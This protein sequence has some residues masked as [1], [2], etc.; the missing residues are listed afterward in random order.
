MVIFLDDFS[1]EKIMLLLVL[2]SKIK[3]KGDTEL[4]FYYNKVKND[5]KRLEE[6]KKKLKQ[7][8]EKLRG[9]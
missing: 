5:L 9:N 3:L 1:N 8:N 6:E 7:E 4:N 2:D